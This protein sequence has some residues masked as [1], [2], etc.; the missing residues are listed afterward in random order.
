MATIIKLC[1]LAHALLKK[2][3]MLDEEVKDSVD[4]VLTFTEIE[5]NLCKKEYTVWTKFKKMP[6]DPPAPIFRDDCIQFQ[7][8]Y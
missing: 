5:K 7:E 2:V 1:L 3:E 8:D 4:E 6:F